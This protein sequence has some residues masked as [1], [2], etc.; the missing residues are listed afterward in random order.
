MKIYSADL[1]TTVY[2]GQ[3]STEA[4]S[5]ALVELGSDTPLIFHSLAETLEYLD[6][7]NEDAILYYHN[8]KFDGNFWLYFLIKE[9]GFKQGIEH[10]ADGSVKI[11][12]AKEL[13]EKEVIYSISSMGQWYTITFK[14]RGHTYTL[15]DSLKLLPF[16]LEEIG[17]AFKTEHR[18][19]EMDYEGYRFSGCEITD[20]ESE[21]IKNDVLVLKEALNIMFDDGHDKLTIGAC[22]LAEYKKMLGKYDWSI[23]FPKLENIEL[24]SE[25]YGSSNADEY[26]R[27]SYRGGW[28]YLV[29]GASG[30]IYKDGTTAD[31]NSLYPSMMHSESGNYYPVGKPKF[32]KG[33][34]PPEA[35]SHHRYYFVRLRCRFYLKK[36]KLPFIQIKHNVNYKSTEML[37]TS[38]VYN[39]KDGKYYSQYYD[40]QGNLHDTI[41]E[42]TM[43]CIDYILFKE[44]YNI[45]DLEILDGCWFYTEIG[46]FDEYINKYKEIKMNN[47]GAKRTEA[48]LFLNNLYGKLATSPVSSFKYIPENDYD[49]LTYAVQSEMEKQPVYIAAGS[50]ITS[51]SRNFTIR[52]AQANF[53]GVDKRGFK[54]ADTD[55]IHCDLKPSEIKGIKVHDNAFCAWKLESCWDIAKFI[56]Q[57]TYVEHVTHEDLKPIEKPFYNIK[58]AGM[59]ET[60]KNLFLASMGEEHNLS[61]KQQKKYKKFIDKPRTL[62]DFKIGLKIPAKLLPKVIKGGVVLTETEFTMRDI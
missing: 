49:F 31:V 43:T 42:L 24:D 51:Y 41:V 54:Y 17:E 58:C 40:K 21:Y 32:F 46:I 56:R 28:C 38:D 19:L 57:K 50:A 23:F 26:I 5:S 55:S 47:K 13:K 36:G 6:S 18:K 61:E 16:K 53:Y 34:I 30:K 62:D 10:L 11:K 4:W 44:H 7:Q 37:E 20:E 29:R 8:L 59:P 9:L 1:E 52:A 25:V 39:K 27:K 33:N 22:C 60:C 35:L 14:Y 48:K 3:T 15:K 12:E 45:Y 2:E